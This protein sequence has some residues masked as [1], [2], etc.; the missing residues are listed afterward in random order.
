MSNMKKEVEK[1]YGSI[2]F[3]ANC[4]TLCLRLVGWIEELTLGRKRY[5]KC[6]KLDSKPNRPRLIQPT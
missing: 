3:A 6:G 2:W 5:E 1:N 4:D